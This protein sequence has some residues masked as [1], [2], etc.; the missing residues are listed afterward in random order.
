MKTR[1]S[2]GC[3]IPSRRALLLL[4]GGLDST[5]LLA[6]TTA[7]GWEVATIFFDYGQPNA[8]IERARAKF[9]AKEYGSV[10]HTEAQLPY[11]LSKRCGSYYPGRNLLLL[12][13][14]A[15]YAESEKLPTIFIG[16]VVT[17]HTP[18]RVPEY[19]D[20]GSEFLR[21]FNET[22]KCSAGLCL[23]VLAPLLEVQKPG[24]FSLAKRLGVDS[25]HTVSCLVGQACGEC[26]SC[27]EREFAQE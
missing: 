24:I 13:A 11:S 23:N 27:V 26:Q 19:P 15:A 20:C 14:A 21:Q 8:D 1:R 12:S 16:L 7:Q 10:G 5:T 9:C 3:K 25:D 18:W 17:T 6:L 2:K 22:L 4:S